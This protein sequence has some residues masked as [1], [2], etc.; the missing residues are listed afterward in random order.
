MEEL[1]ENDDFLSSQIITYIGNKRS[2]LKYIED[3]IKI[4]CKIRKK[5]RYKIHE[6]LRSNYSAAMYLSMIA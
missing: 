2:L 6:N 4:I 3:E 5:I 1:K